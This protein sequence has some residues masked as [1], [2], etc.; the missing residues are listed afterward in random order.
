MADVVSTHRKGAYYANCKS[1]AQCGR[2]QASSDFPKP[3]LL[4]QQV[5]AMAYLGKK[6]VFRANV[7]TEVASPSIAYLLVRVHS[8]KGVSNF[9]QHVP[10]TSDKWAS[11]EINGLVDADAHDIELGMQIQGHGNAWLDDASLRF[12]QGPKDLRK[13]ILLPDPHGLLLQAMLLG[14]KVPTADPSRQRP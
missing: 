7:R 11:Y 6:F 14:P 8:D 3:C 1:G 2:L 9:F 5:D 12:S 13:A 4:G 10:I